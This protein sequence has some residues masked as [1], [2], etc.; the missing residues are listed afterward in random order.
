MVALTADKPEGPFR[1]AAKNF[2]LLSDPTYF[3][4]F[5]PQPVA[6]GLGSGL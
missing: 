4:R 1:A 5:F 6:C 3:S 2:R